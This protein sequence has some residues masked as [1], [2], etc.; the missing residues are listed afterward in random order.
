M[1]LTFLHA[2]IAT[3]AILFAAICGVWGV[4]NYLRKERVSGN[5]W[6]T[7]AIGELLMVA[8]G[9]L[10]VILWLEAQRPARPAMHILYGVVAIIT[11]PAAYVFTQGR[12][13]RHE[14]LIYGVI[15]LFMVGITVRALMTA[16]P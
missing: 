3:A 11:W 5:Y 2:R 9:V 6:G 12:D 4:I 15:G 8:Q 13:T 14:S 1:D 10:G 7:L 16:R